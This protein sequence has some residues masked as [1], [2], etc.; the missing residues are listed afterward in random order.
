MGFSTEYE[1]EDD[2]VGME[3][4]VRVLYKKLSALEIL[5]PKNPEKGYGNANCAYTVG[6]GRKVRLS[7]RQ[8]N[9]AK[10]LAS[11][12]KMK[13]V[14][15]FVIAGY[16]YKRAFY[17]Y[18]TIR[19]IRDDLAHK[20]R[21]A[22]SKNVTTFLNYLKQDLTA[23][24]AIDAAWVLNESVSLYEETRRNGN[25]TQAVRLLHDIAMHVD[26]DARVSSK[27]E[28][29]QTIDYASLLQEAA[30][31]ATKTLS[32]DDTETSE[33]GQIIEGEV[34]ELPSIKL[35]EEKEKEEEL[36][37]VPAELSPT[38]I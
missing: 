26:V 24:L 35:E 25:Y 13:A 32:I 28:I 4:A 17:K 3:E 10:L 29:T 15:A 8:V 6:E 11:N 9:L 1:Q 23:E 21:T 27:I 34:V 14:D 5:L 31:R 16:A 20:F 12:P 36:V 22:M 33:I 37:P 2:P 18:K 38:T 30:L 7:E 19:N